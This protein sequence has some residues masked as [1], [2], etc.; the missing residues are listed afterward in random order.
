MDEKIIK[1]ILRVKLLMGYDNSKTLSNNLELFEEKYS[2]NLNLINEENI[3]CEDLKTPQHIIEI[4]DEIKDAADG[5]LDMFG[6]LETAFAVGVEKLKSKEDVIELNK[7]IKCKTEFSSLKNWI[8][9]EFNEESDWNIK[10]KRRM[11][12]WLNGLGINYNLCYNC[13][14]STEKGPEAWTEGSPEYSTADWFNRVRDF[15]PQ[16]GPKK[17]KYP[18]S[19]P[20]EGIPNHPRVDIAYTGNIEIDKE[21]WKKRMRHNYEDG[22][23]A[24]FFGEP[25]EQSTIKFGQIHHP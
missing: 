20:Q 2:G 21:M 12:K 4:F 1:E 13:K 6:T 17:Y 3:K 8:W 7:Y 19:T 10:V 11:D 23:P 16:Y 24:E 18:Y 5:H 15:K 22:Y 25:E 9:Y 14:L